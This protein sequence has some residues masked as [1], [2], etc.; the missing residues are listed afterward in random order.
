MSAARPARTVIVDDTA[1]LRDMLRL[2]LTHHGHVVVGEAGDGRSGITVVEQQQ[3][4]LV[5]LDLSMPVMD[6]LEALPHLR[7]G[8]PASTIVVLSGFGAEQVA[9]RALRAGA[10]GY[11]Q[12]GTPLV[13]IL[14]RIDAL[15]ADADPGPPRTT[16][17]PPDPA[18]TGEDPGEDPGEHV[19]ADP[20]EEAALLRRAIATAAHEIRGPVTVLRG[21][22]EASADPR[23]GDE[24]RRRMMAAMARQAWLLDAITADL[25]AC[26][27]SR[28]GTL[29]P[30]LQHLD[31]E[32][33]LRALAEDQQHEVEVRVHDPRPVLADPLHLQQMVGNLLR[34][35]SKYAAPPYAVVVRPSPL[36]GRVCID[37]TDRGP[38]VPEAFRPRLF[39]EFSRAGGSASSGTGLGLAVVR[40]LAQAHGGS[41]EHLP[42]AGGGSVFTLTLSAAAGPATDPGLSPRG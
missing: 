23:I 9:D 2:C 16:P 22:A 8:S 20:G 29:D 7:R 40:A 28:R 35:A 13:T 15:L 38:G 30:M 17:V 33:L 11:V 10:H 6:G 24:Q 39:D 32:P 21:M 18:P 1:D 26:A 31:P 5:L 37:V 12:K 41:V 25:L 3:P 34:N 27:Q 4:D 42:R 36:P 14:S 19:R